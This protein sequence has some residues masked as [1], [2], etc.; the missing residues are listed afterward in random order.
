MK[1]AWYERNGPADEVLVVGE[2]PDPHPGVGEVRIRLYA[3]GVNPSDAKS[4]GGSA[5]KIAFPRQVPG[6]DGAGVI[7]EI[8]AGVPADRLGQR[9]WTWNAAWQRPF[10][11]S[12]EYVVLPAL[13]A[14]PLPEGAGFDAGA[15]LGIPVITAHRAVFADGSPT[16]QTVLV[17]GGAGVVGHYAVQLARWAGARVITTVSSADKADH[18][19][20]GG[21]DAVIDYKRED[22]AARVLELTGGEGV[23]RIVEVE[24]AGNLELN[25]RVAKMDAV[26]A[27]YGSMTREPQIPFFPLVSRNLVL[28]LVHMYGLP[29]AAKD[30]AIRDIAAWIAAGRAQFA[31]AERYPLE[32]IVQAHQAVER[33]AKVGHVLLDIQ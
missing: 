2:L 7:D 32:R 11:T 21:A 25:L 14:V 4:R 8:G 18:A 30:H 23:D 33:G 12:A 29:Q 28:R 22:V 5:R 20:A 9:V 26:I 3:S 24:F 16:G 6:S 10:G 17:S 13:Q 31:I 19:R 15:C 27:T 1:A